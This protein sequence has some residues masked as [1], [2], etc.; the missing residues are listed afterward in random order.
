MGEVAA[1]GVQVATQVCAAPR[2]AFSGEDGLED[3]REKAVAAAVDVV[4][5]SARRG[6]VT[7][8][9]SVAHIIRKNFRLQQQVMELE[10]RLRELETLAGLPENSSAFSQCQEDSAGSQGPECS[11]ATSQCPSTSESLPESPSSQRCGSAP[12]HYPPGFPRPYQCHGPALRKASDPEGGAGFL[13]GRTRA[14]TGNLSHCGPGA[15]SS[16]V[17]RKYRSISLRRVRRTTTA[18]TPFAGR[19]GRPG[20]DSQ[21]SSTASL[22]QQPASN[23]NTSSKSCIVTVAEVHLSPE[24]TATTTT[25]NSTEGDAVKMLAQ[26]LTSVLQEDS[27]NPQE[28]MDDLVLSAPHPLAGCECAVCL[29]LSTHPDVLPYEIVTDEGSLLP[30]GST[31]LVSGQRVGTVVYFGH[32]RHQA[33]GA[34]SPHRLKASPTPQQQQQLPSS[35]STQQAPTTGS[36]PPPP[37]QQLPLPAAPSSCDGPQVGPASPIGV[38]VILWPPDEGEVFVP[39]NEVICQLDDEGI[40]GSSE[41]QSSLV[42]E[43]DDRRSVGDEEDTPAILHKGSTHPDHTLTELQ[44]APKGMTETECI[45]EDA[46]PPVTGF[47]ATENREE[48][49]KHPRLRSVSASHCSYETLEHGNEAAE[50]DRGEKTDRVP[51]THTLARLNSADAARKRTHAGMNHSLPASPRQWR[52]FE[53]DPEAHY[54]DSDKGKLQFGDTWDSGCYMSLGR[55]SSECSEQFSDLESEYSSTPWASSLEEAL[56]SV[57]KRHRQRDAHSPFPRRQPTDTFFVD[58][59]IELQDCR[60]L[61]KARDD[62]IG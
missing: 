3:E 38:T 43:G 51:K 42:E 1:A 46:L 8:C 53:G 30:R 27:T 17:R 56:D 15:R 24:T 25:T 61:K 20:G 52:E 5:A 49:C 58:R 23:S 11:S 40:P 59:E 21:R 10:G 12:P 60:I 16:F 57:W 22:E 35:P 4:A 62:A 32:C 28:D 29:Q 13:R 47:G 18:I 7:L 50:S 19:Q 26:K 34:S 44:E 33:K 39:L 45:M 36:S 14:S 6:V 41:E 37:H 48:P 55:Q 2:T 9:A 54:S 31:V